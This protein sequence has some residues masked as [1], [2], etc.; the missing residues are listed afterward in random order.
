MEN[1]IKNTNLKVEKQPNADDDIT[2]SQ[3]ELLLN[4]TEDIAMDTHEAS[5][6]NITVV[7]VPASTSAGNGTSGSAEQ[8]GKNSRTKLNGSKK[9]RYKWLRK[10]GVPAEEAIIQCHV[11]IAGREASKLSTKIKDM[12]AEKLA[13][14]KQ[15]E[16]QKR[17]RSDT[18]ASPREGKRIKNDS[19]AKPKPKKPSYSNVVNQGILLGIAPLNYPTDRL[20]DDDIN[21][22]RKDVLRLI[23]EQRTGSTKPKFTQGASA[24]AG[25]LAIH[26][27]NE[28]TVKWIRGQK[29]WEDRGYQVLAEDQIP[30]DYTV[31]AYI[32]NCLG[33][34]NDFILGLIQGCNEGLDTKEWK[35]I[36]RKDDKEA[37]LVI[38]TMEI[39]RES[40]EAI[41]AT[42]FLIDYGM[43][44]KV[45]LRLVSRESKPQRE[46]NNNPPKRQ[47]KAIK[48]PRSTSTPAKATP[49]PSR[50][51]KPT[52]DKPSKPTPRSQPR[53]K[54]K[55][56]SKRTPKYRD[57]KPPDSKLRK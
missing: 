35:V 49:G 25:W 28:E 34:E 22:V 17:N 33:D 52:A 4:P 27:A 23:Y 42:K 32:K 15:K 41:K 47:A 8:S 18:T 31:V 13:S 43:G 46:S 14:I 20:N 48:G 39:N 55:E 11:P 3:E 36:H 1:S 21:Q 38:L 16:G 40:L 24:R 6:I 44:Q 51:D 37:N 56:G 2:L 45:K 9:R 50:T 26:C 53:T 29:L 7:E 54:D 19:G 10:Q 30:K 57:M 12:T 5:E